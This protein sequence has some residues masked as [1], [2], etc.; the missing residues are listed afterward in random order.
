MAFDITKSAE[1]I[2][3]M[4]NYIAKVRPPI[5]IRPKLDLEYQIEGQ[6]I[7]LN[8]IRSAWDNPKKTLTLGYAKATF[9]KSKNIWKVYWVRSNGEWY[10]YDPPTARSL[11]DFLL[12]V[13]EDKFGCFHG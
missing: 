3:I 4:E 9:V 10:P 2:E 8:E 12:L 5:E 13:D 7:I 11:K 6:S 1:T